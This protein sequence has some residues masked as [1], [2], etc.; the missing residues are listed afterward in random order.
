MKHYK[1]WIIAGAALT[2]ANLLV[3]RKQGLVFDRMEETGTFDNEKK[4]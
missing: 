1:R 2:A 4:G 3:L